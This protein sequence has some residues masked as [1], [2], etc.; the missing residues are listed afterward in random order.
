MWILPVMSLYHSLSHKLLYI[1]HCTGISHMMWQHLCTLIFIQNYKAVCKRIMLVTPV[2]I[3]LV[4][5]PIYIWTLPIFLFFINIKG[6]YIYRWQICNAITAYDFDVDGVMWT[7]NSP[8][9]RILMDGAR[10][11]LIVLAF[12][13]TCITY[14]KN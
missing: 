8:W 2:C 14:M 5:I 10:H 1:Q 4:I 9:C 3:N 11:L 12:Q 7:G 13:I 6:Y